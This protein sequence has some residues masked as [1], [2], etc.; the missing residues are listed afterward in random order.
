MSMAERIIFEVVDAGLDVF[1]GDPRKFERF[2]IREIELE[3][4]EAAKGRL[5]FAGGTNSQGEPVPAR[6]PT[7]VHGYARTGGPFPV[8]AITL[9]AERSVQEYLNQDAA[10]LDEDG[11]VYI[12]EDTG[13]VLDAKARRVEYTYNILVMA[14]HPDVTLWYYHLLKLIILS[15]LEKLEARHLD[16]VALTGSDLVPDPRYLPHDMFG[17]TLTVTVQTDE[18]WAIELEDGGGTQVSGIAVN[19]ADGQTAGI[20]SVSVKAG[21]TPVGS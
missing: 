14:D 11:E 8:W 19:D 12:D 15:S 2:L 5:Y 10:A 18:T 6:P 4:D 16:D 7:L 1:K 20:S 17:R 3:P 21:V 13:A 9:A